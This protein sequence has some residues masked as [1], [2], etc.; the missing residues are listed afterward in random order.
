MAINAK[1]STSEP[2]QEITIGP[3]DTSRKVGRYFGRFTHLHPFRLP[4]F[5]QLIHRFIGRRI[6]IF[7]VL[8]EVAALALGE[9][10]LLSFLSSRSIIRQVHI[11]LTL[12]T[13][14]RWLFFKNAL[15][16]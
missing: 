6:S 12:L 2:K 16:S 1:C 5:Q 13:K 15:L 7:S 11:L 3:K 14:L 4:T 9:G 8:Q 10:R